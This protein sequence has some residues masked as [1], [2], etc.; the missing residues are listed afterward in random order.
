MLLGEWPGPGS[1][2]VKDHELWLAHLSRRA[3]LMSEH[4]G[5]DREEQVART[6]VRRAGRRMRGTTGGKRGVGRSD[7]Q[8]APVLSGPR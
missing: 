1:V 8:P 6:F 3:D 4:D 5:Y 2:Q 7:D